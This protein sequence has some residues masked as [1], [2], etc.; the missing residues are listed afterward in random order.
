MRLPEARLDLEAALREFDIWITPTLGEIRDTDRFRE[1]MERIVAVFEA[2]EGAANSFANIEDC[3][4]S[5]IAETFVSIIQSK[6][7]DQEVCHFLQALASVLFLV[8]GKSDNNAKCQLPIFLRDNA[9]WASIPMVR[10]TR[11]KT[12]GKLVE[13]S[14][15][16]E[17]KAE[18]FVGMVASL[19]EHPGLQRKLLDVFVRFILSD[20]RCVSQ[21]WSIGRSYY[22]LKEFKRERDLLSPLV[23]FQVRGSVSASGGHQPEELLR[24]L[25]RDWGLEPDVDFNLSDAVVAKDGGELKAAEGEE[26]ETVR[27]KTRAYDFVLPFRTPGWRPRMF[28][29]CQFYAGDSGSVSHKN[30]DQTSASRAAVTAI[31]SEAVFVEYVDGAGYFSSLNGDLRTLLWMPTTKT[32]FQVRSAAIRLRRELQSIGFLTPLEIEQAILRT[33]GRGKQLTDLLEAEGYAAREISRATTRGVE[34]GLLD[35]TDDGTFRIRPERRALAR[36]YLLLD[37]IA[38]DGKTL[39]I[40]TEKLAG[41]LLVSGYGSF[42]GIKMDEAVSKAMTVSVLV[43]KDWTNPEVPLQDIRWLCESGLAMSS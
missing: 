30:V 41:Y 24:R 22:A 38:R 25:L 23:V 15:P 21:L 31:D 14:L 20:D 16:R 37:T 7:N 1:E 9:K 26:T 43:R 34:R 40:S 2:L 5:S 39:D 33:G 10:R 8:T 36:R 17:L 32:F 19:G 35:R 29:Q 3:Q 11:S 18:K 13:A 6:E 28:V 27:E 4:P 42:H 12:A